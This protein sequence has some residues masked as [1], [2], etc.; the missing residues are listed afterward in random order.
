MEN[1]LLPKEKESTREEDIRALKVKIKELEQELERLNN[2]GREKRI[3]EDK[4][5]ELLQRSSDI[6]FV[7]CGG[8]IVLITPKGA[9]FLGG[10]STKDIVGEPFL[11]FVPQ[12]FRDISL[13][14]M[15]KV[16]EE[17]EEVG[18]IEGKIIRL[19]G[20][21]VDVDVCAT[22]SNYRGEKAIKSYARDIS[23]RKKLEED[24]KES[25]KKLSRLSLYQKT[26][27]EKERAR[28]SR[29]LHDEIGQ[30]LTVLKM[31]ITKSIREPEIIEGSVLQNL[32]TA[33]EINDL[34]IQKVSE[35]SYKLRPKS[36]DYLSFSGAVRD[37]LK[38]FQSLTG[39]ECR[40]ISTPEDI[41]LSKKITIPIF[42]IF[43]EGT[44]N[45]FHHSKATKVKILMR[46]SD[47]EFFLKI[48][49]NG[50]G[51]KREN[52][53]DNRSLGIADMIDRATSLGGRL[54]IDPNSKNGTILELRIPLKEKTNDKNTYSR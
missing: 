19:D 33:L 7:H 48:S 11:N 20:K 43:Q 52:I 34:T 23:E 8:K 16:L 50:I 27:L 26:I 6:I 17:G 38:N 2:L 49:D 41:S 13:Q 54:K 32:Q 31:N 29:E 39:I 14:R 15:R 40:I 35:I 1:R 47:S 53:Y 37:Y 24:L 9:R 30:L 36:L 5:E 44:S 12:N 22:P 10:K 42:R 21:E 25:N 51:I 28:I 45:V 46:K 18:F 4:Y 3:V